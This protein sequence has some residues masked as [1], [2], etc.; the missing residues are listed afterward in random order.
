MSST[1]P[2]DEIAP[3]DPRIAAV[4]VADLVAYFTIREWTQSALTSQAQIFE[5]PHAV[6]RGTPAVI[7]LPLRDRTAT[8]AVRVAE[9]LNLVCALEGRPLDA[10]LLDVLRAGGAPGYIHAR[11]TVRGTLLDIGADRAGLVALRALIDQALATDAERSE[12]PETALRGPTG[13]NLT[14]RV[15]RLGDERAQGRS[16]EERGKQ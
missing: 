10:V 8:H 11:E 2:F 3:N 9:A 6:S 16:T 12:L 7:A 15:Q 13:A 4:R 1:L 5:T 14:V